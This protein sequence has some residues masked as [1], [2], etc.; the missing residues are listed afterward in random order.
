MTSPGELLVDADRRR[1]PTRPLGSTP[2]FERVSRR[3]A[4][5]VLTGIL[6]LFGALASWNAATTGYSD[7]YATAARSMSSNWRAFAFGAFDP[8]STITLDK[9]SGFLVPQALAARV[10]GFHAW[11]LALPQVVFG[12]VTIAVTYAIVTRLL[13]RFGGLVAALVTAVLPVSVT[14]F[15]HPMEDAMLTAFVTLA[16]W[17][18][19]RALDTGL[20]RYLLLAAL[21]VGIAFQ[22]KMMQAWLVVPVLVGLLLWQH[23]RRLRLGVANVALAIGT[24]AVT[25]LAWAATIQLIPA[26]DRPYIDGT[27]DDSPLTMVLGYNGL[28][29]FVGGAYP[30]ALG[31]GASLPGYGNVGLVPPGWA[32]LPVKLLL[33]VY[34]TQVGWLYPLAAAG[35]VL[36]VVALRRRPE[37]VLRGGSLPGLARAT[38]LGTGLLLVLGVVLGLMALPHTAYLEALVLPLSI[39]CAVGAILLGRL[40]AGSVGRR[41]LAV[42]I[43]LTVQ[44]TWSLV[45]LGHYPALAGPLLVPVAVAG[46]GA[47]LWF[48]AAGRMPVADSLRIAVAAVAAVACLTGPAL[49]SLSTL[50]PG[51]AGSA[52]DAYA[53]PPVAGVQALITAHEQTRGIGLDSDAVAPATAARERAMYAFALRE[54]PGSRFALATDSWRS[55]GPLL[56]DGARRILPIGGFTGR[57]GSPDVAEL[58]RLVDSGQLRF[59]LLTRNTAAVE[60]VGPAERRLDDWVTGRCALV[61]AYDHETAPRLPGV[62]TADELYRCAR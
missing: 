61:P 7:Y 19:L 53:G 48:R 40:A 49:W 62:V 23:R 29:R 26:A 46:Y 45:L 37:W 50:D 52:D 54:A 47:A 2:H 43:V 56:A 10:F 17:A 60:P 13:G 55:A 15:S 3:T 42:P 25:S 38:A 28:D 5:S 58:R 35:I 59:V 39:L 41:R 51:Y 27:T 16:V 30:G 32:H 1:E 24:I 6:I 4:L 57:V 22:A 36:G 12:L 44:T 21:F 18:W 33:P 20:R 11:S 9:L 8:N 34:A 14:T 31:A